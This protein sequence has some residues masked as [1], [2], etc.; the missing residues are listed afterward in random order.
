VDTAPKREA[1]VFLFTTKENGTGLGLSIAE[2]YGSRIWAENRLGGGSILR[3]TLRQT[4]AK[5]T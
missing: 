2:I 4:K 5:A 1:E 3:F